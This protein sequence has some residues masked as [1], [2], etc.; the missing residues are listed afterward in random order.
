MEGQRNLREGEI[1]HIQTRRQES[2]IIL[3]C[4][5]TFECSVGLR[6][7]EVIETQISAGYEHLV[8]NLEHVDFL[9]SMA[10]GRLVLTDRNFQGVRHKVGLLQPQC[11]TRQALGRC[12][13]LEFMRL[14]GTEAE[15]LADAPVAA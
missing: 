5:G 1:M 7:Q 13:P 9:D 8:L 6:I 3:D 15:A 4:E 2:T 14:Y 11:L 10:I 12:N